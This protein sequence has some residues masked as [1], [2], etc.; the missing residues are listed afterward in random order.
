MHVH[1]VVEVRDN[2]TNFLQLEHLLGSCDEMTNEMNDDAWWADRC[3]E[4]GYPLQLGLLSHFKP[5]STLTLNNF[6]RIAP[7]SLCVMDDE[8]WD[9]RWDEWWWM[10]RWHMR[11]MM[12]SSAIRTAMPSQT[13][14]KI[15]TEQLPQCILNWQL[16]SR[17][18]VITHSKSV[19]QNWPCTQ[20]QHS[21]P[22]WHVE[23]AIQLRICQR[24][25][26]RPGALRRWRRR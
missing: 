14:L 3:D 10:M 26:R 16:K 18:G 13:P 12:I 5:L 9:D 11:W 15:D 17:G 23:V 25:W 21:A 1:Q 6:R 19:L 2:F 7:V 20:L 22:D 8:W 24:C 4:W